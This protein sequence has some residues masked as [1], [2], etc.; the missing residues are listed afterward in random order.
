[1]TK[2][3]SELWLELAADPYWRAWRW[4]FYLMAMLV[5]VVEGWLEHG[6]S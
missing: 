3:N 4:E 5:S 6:E 2:P 1:M